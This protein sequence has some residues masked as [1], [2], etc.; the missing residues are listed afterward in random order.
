MYH[1]EEPRI[2]FKSSSSH[3]KDLT[4]EIRIKI[5]TIA[6][7]FSI[8]GTITKLTQRY[9]ISRR[10]VY[11][12]KE[13]LYFY[14]QITESR[15]ELTREETLLKSYETALLL[16]LDGK[17]SI[18]SISSIMKYLDMPYASVG[19]ISEH[20]KLAGSSLENVFETQEN[21]TFAVFAADEIYA[22]SLPILITCDPVSFAILHIKLCES[23]TSKEWE[24]EWKQLGAKGVI[25]L[26][27]AKDEGVQMECAAKEIFPD[28][29]IQSD[30]YHGVAHKL[31]LWH[32]RLETEAFNKI[33]L[34]YE[35]EILLSKAKTDKILNKRELE[36]EQAKINTD[37]A[38]VFL[39]DFEFIYY[40][41]LSSLECIDANG[42]LKDKGH[43]IAKF[44]AA[45][46]LGIECLEHKT[47]VKRLKSI[48]KIQDR[49]FYFYNVA[50]KILQEL[51]K[52]TDSFVLEL[53]CLYWQIDKRVV[54]TKNNKT[55]MR[56][57]IYASHIL[58]DIKE[59][60]GDNFEMIFDKT[61]E[62]LNNIVQSSSAIECINS[63]LRPYLNTCKNQP[64]QEFLNLFMFYHNH[65]RFKAGKR[66]GKTP[67]EL[68][69]GKKQDKNW[70]ELLLLKPNSVRNH[71]LS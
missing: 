9:N 15:I 39:C 61:I 36:Y 10:F 35:K 41:L 53:I 11:D 29:D 14:C 49:L 24:T 16:R 65:R 37:K 20:L 28:V 67:I 18:K 42:K 22:K 58:A 23:C 45:L 51:K 57:A 52:E 8:H 71:L 59:L 5:A 1:Q 26:Y 7:F 30:T 55:A 47:I 21:I 12:L 60:T 2:L 32:K 13:N 63:I 54:K 27:I 19:T 64:T 44:E 46:E 34:E 43:E 68:F 48:S 17:C 38:L 50:E 25:P 6:L 3:R 66:K 70:L 62:K 40:N 33:E 69:T 4:T 31:G 56:I